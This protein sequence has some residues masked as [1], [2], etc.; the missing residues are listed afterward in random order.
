VW[1]RYVKLVAL[2]HH[3]GE[4]YCTLTLVRVHGT[5]MLQVGGARAQ[6]HIVQAPF[7]LR[8]IV[9]I[10]IKVH[11]YHFYARAWHY[12]AT[13]RW[14]KGSSLL[15]TMSL[16]H[17][18]QHCNQNPPLAKQISHPRRL[19]ITIQSFSADLEKKS[20][21]RAA[22]MC[23]AF[24]LHTISHTAHNSRFMHHITIQSFSADLDIMH[25]SHSAN[26][27]TLCKQSSLSI[28]VVQRRS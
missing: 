26:N 9:H 21:Q 12:H 14:C 10:A 3:G 28:T 13:S 6:V 1:L 27:F 23:I 19:C 11:H 7:L 15:M 18:E 25:C 17:C 2:S 24:A 22:D 20:I 5:T 16:L 4:Y 8:T